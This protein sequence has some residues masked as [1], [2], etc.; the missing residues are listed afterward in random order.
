MS[1]LYTVKEVSQILKTNVH[2][3][4]ALIDSGM[5]P[6][7]K[8]GGLK[9]REEALDKFLAEYEGYDLTDL[10]NIVKLNPDMER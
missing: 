1:N 8:L 2:R 7:L 6:A 5:L 9:V 4:Y 3:V 10:G